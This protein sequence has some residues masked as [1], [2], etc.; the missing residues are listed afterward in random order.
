VFFELSPPLNRGIPY[1]KTLHSCDS[2]YVRF[3]F[4]DLRKWEVHQDLGRYNY[5]PS[6]SPSS[7]FISWYQGMAYG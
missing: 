3:P 1:L 6:T 2:Y 5:G 7:G 4:M